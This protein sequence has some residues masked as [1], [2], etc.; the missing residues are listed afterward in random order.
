[1]VLPTVPWRC[2]WWQEGHPVCKNRVVGCSHGYLSGARCRFIY[3]LTLL[4]MQLVLCGVGS[5]GTH[6][7][8]AWPRPRHWVPRPRRDQDNQHTVSK[9][10]ET[11]TLS[12]DP[13]TTSLC[14]HT[15]RFLR[16]LTDL[17]FVLHWIVLFFSLF[18]HTFLSL[19]GVG[20][21]AITLE[22]PSLGVGHETWTQSINADLTWIWICF[23]V[24]WP[25]RRF[26]FHVREVF[27]RRLLLTV[28][29][30]FV[31]A[32]FCATLHS[33]RQGFLLTYYLFC[34]V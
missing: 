29:F 19:T 17:I 11:K 31:K 15:N 13:T 23:L 20:E 7:V 10:L 32:F 33:H 21:P 6:T 18:E 5:D 8:S 26:F 34:T 22:T 27:F 25:W 16:I 4:A 24:A 28:L 14:I 2:R 9:R 12:R 3:C 30:V 1:M